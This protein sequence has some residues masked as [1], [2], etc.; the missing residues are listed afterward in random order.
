M[1]LDQRDTARTAPTEAN[2]SVHASFPRSLFRTSTLPLLSRLGVRAIFSAQLHILH[3]SI[4][5]TA[6]IYFA[7]DI[8]SKGPRDHTRL[9]ISRNVTEV[10]SHSN[11]RRRTSDSPFKSSTPTGPRREALS[12]VIDEHEREGR[13]KTSCLALKDLVQLLLEPSAV[14]V[15]HP[16]GRPAPRLVPVALI[17]ELESVEEVVEVGARF[18]PKLGGEVAA[19]LLPLLA[20]S[21]TLVKVVKASE[22]TVDGRVKTTAIIIGL[23]AKR[24]I[25]LDQI[26]TRLAKRLDETLSLAVNRGWVAA[27]VWIVGQGRSRIRR[28]SDVWVRWDWQG[29]RLESQPSWPRSVGIPKHV[30][31]PIDRADIW[32]LPGLTVATGAIGRRV[33]ERRRRTV[34]GTRRSRHELPTDG[35]GRG[36][37]ADVSNSS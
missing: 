33:R 6:H 1:K 13:S 29:W 17:V 7:T 35:R 5:C 37:R 2:P 24:V 28:P 10:S 18:T 26:V 30:L 14:L 3:T 22:G 27:A 36:V 16:H 32:L 25:C 9:I 23:L 19:A 12:K 15:L 4:R 20:A 11:P 34:L 8:S 21:V 31:V